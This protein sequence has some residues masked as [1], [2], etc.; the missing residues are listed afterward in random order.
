MDSLSPDLLVAVLRKVAGCSTPS[1]ALPLLSVVL[2]S[3]TNHAFHGAVHEVIA[4]LPLETALQ[5]GALGNCTN[6][7]WKAARLARLRGAC[8][9]GGCSPEPRTLAR[10]DD[11]F[12]RGWHLVAVSSHADGESVS[13]VQPAAIAMRCMRLGDLTGFLMEQNLGCAACELLDEQSRAQVALAVCYADHELHSLEADS[14]VDAAAAKAAALARVTL[15]PPLP[16]EDCFPF[17]APVIE[18]L[19]ES[20]A[21]RCDHDERQAE[22][23]GPARE[24]ARA[25]LLETASVMGVVRGS[26]HPSWANDAGR[27]RA[28]LREDVRRVVHPELLR[29][30]L[31]A[32]P[33]PALLEGQRTAIM[34]MLGVEPPWETW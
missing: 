19:A 26:V 21:S 11:N 18:L 9:C 22:R 31:A 2:A 13:T 6:A 5:C 12:G 20:V 30:R 28:L 16:M 4:S 33:R 15:E 8:R 1:D 23:D 14:Y 34:E 27:W 25:A 29:R 17:F 32:R 7:G 24:A 10:I 3:R